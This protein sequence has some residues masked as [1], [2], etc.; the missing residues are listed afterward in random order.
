MSTL[1][2][3]TSSIEPSYEIVLSQGGE[4][5]QRKDGIVPFHPYILEQKPENVSQEEYITALYTLSTEV[6][7]IAE[8]PEFITSPYILR[9]REEALLTINSLIS[10]IHEIK[11]K[12]QQ[13]W[14]SGPVCPYE[15]TLIEYLGPNFVCPTITDLDFPKN[16]TIER[17]VSATISIN[18]K[19]NDLLLTHVNF[20]SAE[21][22][23]TSYPG[24]TGYNLGHAF[25]VLSATSEGEHFVI[26][27]QKMANHLEFAEIIR[28]MSNEDILENP[29]SIAYKLLG[30]Y[31]EINQ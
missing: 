14:L 10:S 24:I 25:T 5:V 31:I 4:L 27:H 19:Y 8:N 12:F 20:M 9:D 30:R 7:D 16:L 2:A 21:A 3:T 29:F 23:N 15:R 13:E 22:A 6:L 28:N 17:A 11:Q 26:D 1:V 18:H